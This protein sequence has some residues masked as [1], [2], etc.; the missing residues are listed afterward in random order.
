MRMFANAA[1]ARCSTERI[2][3]MEYAYSTHKTYSAAHIAL[4]DYFASGEVFEC[5][6]AGIVRR[7]TPH[8]FRYDIMLRG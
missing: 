1:L 5:E 4:Y 7:T 8:G 2:K 6:F 3:A